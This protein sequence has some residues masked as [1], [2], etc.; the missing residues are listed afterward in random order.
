MLSIKMKNLPLGTTV[1]SAMPATSASGVASVLI[2]TLNGG[3]QSK[4]TNTGW[5]YEFLEGV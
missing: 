5:R 1:E 2:P 4:M 3:E